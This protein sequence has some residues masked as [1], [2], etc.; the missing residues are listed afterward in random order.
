MDW[1]NDT[2]DLQRDIRIWLATC[3][4]KP[5]HKASAWTSDLFYDA[6]AKHLTERLNCAW[7]FRRR[8]D[9]GG[10]PIPYEDE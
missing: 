1:E 8:F 6:V 5:P 7:Q 2:D 10:K 4:Y 3:K 9:G